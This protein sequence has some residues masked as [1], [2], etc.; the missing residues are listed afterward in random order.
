MHNG[1][2]DKIAFKTRA[3]VRAIR[4]ATREDPLVPME[5]YKRSSLLTEEQDTCGV[6]RGYGEVSARNRAEFPFDQ[7]GFGDWLI[8]RD[9]KRQRLH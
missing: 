9:P 3:K 1:R 5:R 6:G 7:K 8:I 4:R 2:D